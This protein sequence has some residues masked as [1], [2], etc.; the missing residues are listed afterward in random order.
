MSSPAP[1]AVA[2]EPALAPA[3]ESATAPVALA[4]P[5]PVPASAPV[6]VAVPV[7]PPMAA[8]EPAVTSAP[9]QASL[10]P[11]ETPENPF[12]DHT[13]AALDLP[14][15]AEAAH[16]EAVADLVD[17]M[18]EGALAAEAQPLADLLHAHPGA[19]HPR[20]FQFAWRQDVE[21]RAFATQARQS[22]FLRDVAGEVATAARDLADR[23][24]ELG[25]IACLADVARCARLEQPSRQRA[26]LLHRH[27]EHPAAE[28]AAD[29][30]L[31][32]VQAADARQVQVAD[33]DVRP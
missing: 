20:D 2:P 4:S 28:I 14:P 11:E 26:V 22:Q 24:H 27:H 15:P 12:A 21:R 7:A 30:A 9:V 13:P 8:A 33:D 16:L 23:A 10:I 19:K 1:V 32:D 17:A 5:E 31:G 18:P 6:I 25:R 3:P 29:D